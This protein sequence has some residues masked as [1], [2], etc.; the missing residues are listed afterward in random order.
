MMVFPAVAHAENAKP[1]PIP[2]GETVQI[3]VQPTESVSG[4]RTGPPESVVVAAGH[5]HHLGAQSGQDTVAIYAELT[6]TNPAVP[7]TGQHFYASRIMEKN[8]GGTVWIEIGWAELGWKED[9]QYVYV[10]DSVDKVW[11][12]YGQYPISSGMTI[13]VEIRHDTSYPG[14][15]EAM[16]WWSGSWRILDWEYM[17]FTQG[18]AIEEYGEVY[19]PNDVDFAISRTYFKNVQLMKPGQTV[20]VKWDTQI[21]TS[22][23]QEVQHIYRLTWHNKYY[24]WSIYSV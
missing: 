4:P 19:T 23:S 14:Y 24:Y 5:Y 3:R 6:V 12:L 22:P 15:W 1:Q 8:D 10:Y 18:P 17:G 11:H 7:H 2:P 20:F 9:K 21:P 13:T 16:L